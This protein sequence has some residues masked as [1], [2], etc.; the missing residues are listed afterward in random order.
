MYLM[1][2]EYQNK[3]SAFSNELPQQINLLEN[4]CFWRSLQ[5]SDHAPGPFQ[6][7]QLRR[8]VLR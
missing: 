8:T 3:T 2:L 4:K 6:I 5:L 1:F 7:Q